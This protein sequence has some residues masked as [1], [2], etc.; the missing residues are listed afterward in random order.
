[1][2]VQAMARVMSDSEAG[3]IDR[4]VLLV[5]ANRAGGDFDEC[6]ASVDRLAFECRVDVRTVQRAT[7]RLVASGDLVPAG[8]HP[9]HRTNVYRVMAAGVAESHPPGTTDAP[10]PPERKERSGSGSGVR[11][12]S[13]HLTVISDDDFEAFYA[14]FPTA[15]KGSRRD[16]RKAWDKALSRAAPRTLI[17]GAERYRDDPNREDA[18]TAGAARWLNRDGWEEGPLPAR[19]GRGRDISP[20]DEDAEILAAFRGGRRGAE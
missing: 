3:G 6:F 15:R 12:R 17:E 8:V 5:M 14:A 7:K 13:S 4:L 16:V 1:M 11:S 20:T 19:S 10:V 2:S 18:F 9:R